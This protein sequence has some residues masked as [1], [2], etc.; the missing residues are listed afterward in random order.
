MFSDLGHAEATA[1]W[2][3]LPF[4]ARGNML[5]VRFYR[6]KEQKRNNEAPEYTVVFFKNIVRDVSDGLNR[7]A[8]QI[9]RDH[10]NRWK[11][12]QTYSKTRTYY[13]T[14]ILTAE[15]L[16]AFGVP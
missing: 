13:K 12:E 4:A 7:L 11:T 8:W 1:M 3:E 16:S 9:L 2:N 5:T 15:E 6:S 10:T 14:R